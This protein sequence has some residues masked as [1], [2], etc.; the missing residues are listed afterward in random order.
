MVRAVDADAEDVRQEPQD[1]EEDGGEADIDE[2]RAQ[3]VLE[4]VPQQAGHDKE[5]E[6]P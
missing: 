4:G 2:G 6:G 1:T 5:E 3:V